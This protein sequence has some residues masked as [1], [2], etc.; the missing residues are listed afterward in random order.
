MKKLIWTRGYNSWVMGGYVHQPV[1][2]DVDVNEQVDIGKG[3]KAYVVQSPN[4]KVTVIVE[5]RS[6][7]IIGNT[8]AR[9]KKDI[10]EGDLEVMKKQVSDAVAMVKGVRRMEHDYFWTHYQKGKGAS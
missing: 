3:F 9:V 1:G 2:I 10:A 4:K 7:A 8:L 5:A 6:G